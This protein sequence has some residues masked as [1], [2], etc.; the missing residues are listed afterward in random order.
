MTTGIDMD[1]HSSQ[2]RL[3]VEERMAHLFG[4]LVTLPGREILINGDMQFR[5][6]GVPNPA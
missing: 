6:Q 1:H 3:G 2:L 5:V 4:Y